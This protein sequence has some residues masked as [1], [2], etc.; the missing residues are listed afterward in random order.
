MKFTL[1]PNLRYELFKEAMRSLEEGMGKEVWSGG[2]NLIRGHGKM[3]L[4][5][6]KA[7]DG[8]CAEA[9]IQHDWNPKPAKTDSQDVLPSEVPW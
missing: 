5:N 2:W 3:L 4:K 6:D 8:A 1:G 7:D 9:V